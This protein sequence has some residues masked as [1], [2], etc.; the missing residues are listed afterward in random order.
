M[1]NLLV[2]GGAGYIGSQT[3]KLLHQN[4]YL[5]VSYDNL[6]YGHRE[7]VQWGPLVVGD[8]GDVDKLQKVFDKY[9]P[10]A[11]IHFAAF[12][13]VGES[14][15]NPGKY[16]KN[17]VSGTINLL[18]VMRK[19]GCANIIFSSTC[20]TYGVPDCLPLNENSSQH[21]VNPYGKTKL[22]IEQM[23][24]DYEKAYGIKYISLRYFNAAG[25]DPDGS[26][27]EDHDPETHLI[28]LTIEAALGKRTAIEVYGTDYSTA[29]GTAVRDYIHVADL[30]MAHLLSF[31]YLQSHNTSDVFN[32]GTGIG[33]S[34]Q[35]VVN[36]VEKISKRQVPVVYGERR[37]GDPPI[38]VASAEKAK[39]VLG[40]EP[41]HSDIDS[42]VKDAWNWHS[43]RE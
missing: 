13:Y 37:D 26:L 21:P 4:D 24:E 30:A 42:I 19:S 17:N 28:P 39:D 2:T 15:Q 9:K 14:V 3:C 16:Y 6:I 12:A 25:A 1:K 23:L 10:E 40:W 38:L 18:E 11:V 20:A 27:G 7:S 35:E 29:D 34:V 33:T 5:P 22:M 43:S 8:I 32:L 41:C 31:E 36:V